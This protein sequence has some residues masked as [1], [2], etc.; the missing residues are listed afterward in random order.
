MRQSLFLQLGSTFTSVLFSAKVKISRR[1]CPFL[2][3]K[4]WAAKVLCNYPLT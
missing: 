3:A 4:Y 1:N 2:R